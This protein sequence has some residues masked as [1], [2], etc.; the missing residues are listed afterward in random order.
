MYKFNPDH[1]ARLLRK[2]R[3]NEIR[4]EE[5]LRGAG[6][7]AGDTF[8]DVGAGPGFFSIPASKVVGRKGSVYAVDTE[9]RMLSELRK[10]R[11]PHNVKLLKSGENRIPAPASTADFLLIAYVL[12]E[13]ADG[14]KFL[15][16]MRRVLKA[17]SKI[18]IIDWKKKRE[19]HG[20][21][22]G[23]RLIIKAVKELLK[24]A[25]FAD[26]KSTSLN[27]S[28]YAVTAVN[29]KRKR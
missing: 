1:I 23:E 29:N 5:V 9:A 22:A 16:E 15:G 19:A 25:G 8:F 3:Y 10:R 14:L 24:G 12:H 18:F 13:T 11:P 4:P 2:D 7:K 28:H 17:G 27:A 6:L 20:P 26:I 21:P